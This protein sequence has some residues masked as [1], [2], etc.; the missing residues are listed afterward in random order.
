MRF[1]RRAVRNLLPFV[2]RFAV[3]VGI[4]EP[5]LCLIFCAD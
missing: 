3:N 2:A 5:V 1:L 4:F